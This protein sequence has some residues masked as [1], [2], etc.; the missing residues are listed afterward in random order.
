LIIFTDRGD[1]EANV[2]AADNGAMISQNSWG[3]NSAGVYNQSALD[4]ID[5]FNANGGGTALAGGLTIFAAGN[6]ND[7]GNWYPAYYGY[8]DPATLGAMAVASTDI[9]DVRSSFSNY[10]EWV[11]IAAPGSNI[12]S[13]WTGSGYNSISGTSMACPH[14]SGVASAIVPLPKACLQM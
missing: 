6:D 13:T 7:N 3:Y 4:G 5:Y 9:N 11:D 12:Y 1:Y 8:N 14:V 10:G 2:Y